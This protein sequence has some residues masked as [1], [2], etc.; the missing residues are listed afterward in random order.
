MASYE[1]YFDLIKRKIAQYDVEPQNMYNIDEKGF[2]LGSMTKQ[3]RVFTKDAVKRGRIKGFSHDGN[4][5]WITILATIC[6]N[7]S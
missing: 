4:R 5:E 3:H 1:Y 7:G 2:S 6:A